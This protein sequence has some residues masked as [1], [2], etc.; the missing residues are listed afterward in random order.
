MT[1]GKRD[2]NRKQKKIFPSDSDRDVKI[3]YDDRTAGILPAHA[4]FCVYRRKPGAK[5]RRRHHGRINPI[6]T[7][8]EFCG[9]TAV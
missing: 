3:W 9:R 5:I 1:R 4:G 7:P 8:E 6:Q 2:E